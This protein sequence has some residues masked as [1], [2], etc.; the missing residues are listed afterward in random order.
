MDLSAEEARVLGAL[1]EKQLTTPQ[2][3]PLTLHALM[4]AC[5]QTSNRQPVVAYEEAV[6]DEAIATLRER[7]LVRSVLPSHGRSVVRFRQV[8]DEAFGLDERRLSLVAVLLLR[9]PQTVGELRARTERMAEF[10]STADVE[11]DLVALGDLTE[12]LVARQSRRPGQKEDR[13][14]E[15]LS[16]QLL[17]DAPPEVTVIRPTDP[18]DEA[19]SGA[20]AGPA[21]PAL[22][23][24]ASELAEL[25]RQVAEL[26]SEV[27]EL[28]LALAEL[29]A[30]LGG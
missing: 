13:W 5:N 22:E 18:R 8:L 2:Q 3:Y 28:Q 20:V 7:G 19:V 27:R 12:P 9:G 10:S 21:A 25:R 16:G 26:G 30:A 24:A 23:A 4:A 29:R 1:T 15:R 17:E 6:V 14:V 11:H